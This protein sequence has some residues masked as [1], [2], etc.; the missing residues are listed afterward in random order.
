MKINTKPYVIFCIHQF[1]S[2]DQKKSKSQNGSASER[3]WN[4]MWMMRAEKIWAVMDVC[5]S[6][7]FQFQHESS[8]QCTQ[9]QELIKKEAILVRCWSMW[10]AKIVSTKFSAYV[11]EHININIVVKEQTQMQTCL[12][13]LRTNEENAKEYVLSWRTPCSSSSSS[14]NF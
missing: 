6:D 12:F 3:E 13:M 2:W 8:S 11:C 9:E 10:E 5:S 7:L 14:F 4:G 1:S